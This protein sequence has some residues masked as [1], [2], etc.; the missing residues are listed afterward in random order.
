MLGAS[1]EVDPDIQSLS[2]LV[3]DDEPE[4]QRTVRDMLTDLG[5]TQMF[6]AKNGQEALDFL[7]EVEERLDVIIADWNM[8]KLSG[9]DLLKQVR[10]VDEDVI[11]LLLTGRADRDSVVEAQQSGVSAYLR[12]PFSQEQMAGKLT[13]LCKRRRARE[14]AVHFAR[15]RA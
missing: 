1:Q 13:L 8:P 7:G 5:V 6:F 12:K 14:R 2:I 11:F 3:V 9:L 15:L 10:T 4:V